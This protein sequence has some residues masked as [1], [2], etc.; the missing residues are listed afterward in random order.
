[1]KPFFL[2]NPSGHYYAYIKDFKTDQWLNFND[3]RVTKTDRDEIKKAYGLSYSSYSSTAAYML[4]YRQIDTNRNEQALVMQDF[5]QHI[6]DLLKY[7]QEQFELAEK[8]K[9]YMNNLSKIKVCLY[10]SDCTSEI[11]LQR[12]PE[13]QVTIHRDLTLKQAKAEIEREF[14]DIDLIKYKTRLLKYDLYNEIIE[15]SYDDESLTVNHVL[16]GK[17]Y[18]S[19]Q[20]YCIVY[21]N[22]TKNSRLD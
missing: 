7:E 19:C 17:E 20:R 18:F 8:Q 6:N 2:A 4:F 22:S 10:T 14:S 9:Q 21:K 16:N 13:K 5:P 12:L 3:E 15:Q 1:M 11:N